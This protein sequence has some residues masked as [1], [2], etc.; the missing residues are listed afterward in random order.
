[1]TTGFGEPAEHVTRLRRCAEEAQRP[2]P[3]AVRLSSRR[4]HTPA[5]APERPLPPGDRR[6]GPG[7]VRETARAR[8]RHTPALR[9]ETPASTTDPAADDTRRE[10]DHRHLD[11]VTFAQQHCKHPQPHLTDTDSRATT[12]NQGART[13]IAGRSR[14]SSS[15]LRLARRFIRTCQQPPSL[16]QNRSTF[17]KKPFNCFFQRKKAI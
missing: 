8:K 3:A 15:T 17:Q 2:P 4:P 9:S 11:S 1:M 10:T 5:P 12:Q 13:V 16:T 7:T 14:P 6:R